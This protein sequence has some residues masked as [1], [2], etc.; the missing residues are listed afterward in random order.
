MSELNE[1]KCPACGGAVKFDT[2]SQKVKCPFC[3]CEFDPE[4]IAGEESA[5]APDEMNWDVSD[6]GNWQDDT[7]KIY[8]C[9][10]CGGEIVCD[11]NASAL[12]CPYC[13][14]PVVL[15]GNLS[16][17]LKPDYIIPFKLD[18]KAAKNAMQNYLKGK[19]LLPKV[20]KDE[21]HIDEMRAVYVPF[22]LFDGKAQGDISFHG[23]RSTFWSDSK[24]DYTR[25][26]HFS[27]FRSGTLQFMNLPADGS[28]KM[29]NDLMESLEPYDFS[30]AKEFNKGY[31][32]GFTADKYD[33]TAQ[34]CL[35][36]VNQRI[37]Q[38]TE[39]AFMHTVHGYTGVYAQNSSVRL[40]ENT[41]K[42]ALYPVWLLNT[43]W[44]KQKYTF[45]MNG[46]TGKFV[47]NLPMDK[48]LFRKW[49]FSL[50]GIITAAFAL[51][52]SLVWLWG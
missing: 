38:S 50:W 41:V 52:L 39:D 29:P 22:W 1:Y 46:Q 35:D 40:S 36:R 21:N 48:K 19:K 37:K 23:T 24:Y 14:N 31:L 43:T 11:E 30:E 49:L 2:A 16:G 45:A 20:F 28:K 42:Y 25:T 47:G 6:D 33:V 7:L 27:I 51:L 12:S 9:S 8:V 5:G 4:A 26:S 44:N 13:D 10:S 32:L 3:D 18:K 15:S 34:M 17:V